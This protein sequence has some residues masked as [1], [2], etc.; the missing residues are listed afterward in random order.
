MKRYLLAP[1]RGL[2]LAAL[3]ASGL[4]VAMATI[5][6][7]ALIVTYPTLV[8][9]VRSYAELGRRLARAWSGVEISAGYDPP[10]PP[11][12][13]RADGWY[14]HDNQLYRSPRMP[15]F[16]VRVEA[17]SKDSTYVR[18]WAWLALTPFAGGLA[19]ALPFALIAAGVVVAVG[20]TGPPWSPAVALAAGLALVGGGLAIGPAALRLHARWS[21]YLLGPVQESWWRTSGLGPW[22]RRAMLN[23]WR[24]AGLAGMGLG[25]LGIL[26]FHLVATVISWGGLYPFVVSLTRPYFDHY[27]RRA[28]EW[29]GVDFPPPYRPLPEPPHP[30]ETGRYRVGRTLYAS[31]DG[32]VRAQRWYWVGKDPA[33]WRDLL[34]TVTNAPAGL[35]GLI[36][37]VLVAVG[38]YGL[39]WQPISWAPWAVPIGLTDGYWVTPWYMWYG[40][41]M[42]IPAL[43]AVPG[44]VSP[45]IG[46]AIGVV[47]MLLAG[48]LLRLRTAYD[49][50]LL[51]PT[52]STVLA[53]RVRQL[54]ETRADATDAQAAEL[55]R[56]ER[57]L[58]DG[59]QARL[60]AVGISLA[61]V[62]RLMESDPA[63]ARALVAQAR[64]TSATA[65]SELRDL[66]RGI[67]PPV[68]A[69]RGLAEAVRAIAL[70]TPLPV[71]VSADVPGRLPAPVEAAAY[72]ATVEALANA[73]R[74]GQAGRVRIDLRH[75][76][77]VLRISVSDDGR[78]GADPERGSGLRGIRRRLGTFD[79]VL[80]VHS[81]VGGP[82]VVTME[83]PCA[84]SS[85]RTSTSSGTA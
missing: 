36:P 26:V 71:E 76:D 69:E 19:A 32:A 37:A 66:V 48:P 46:V 64:E 7:L 23:T 34:W 67:H 27:R 38:V 17:Y 55:R 20:A 59:A 65:L 14:V 2:V 44:W 82:T 50:R 33:T 12:Q 58:H 11:P 40:L 81:P 8:R 31:R 25:A 75:T 57:D 13:P 83:I 28:A 77:G 73:A 74:H 84:L 72:F 61:T 29:T 4:V 21:R 18:D 80:Q 43:A 79:G 56:I 68:L 16:F 1:V 42:G 24:G 49:Q 35:L 9:V 41:T 78:G 30:D 60:V 10:P 51:I 54:T 47:G 70:D 22:V 62:E 39:V 85:P 3:A 53:H 5:L 6:L 45:F 63:A 52:A 15:A